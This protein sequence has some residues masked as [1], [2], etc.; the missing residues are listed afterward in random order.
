[1]IEQRAQP[2]SSDRELEPACQCLPYPGGAAAGQQCHILVN[3]AVCASSLIGRFP[4]LR[5]KRNR[6]IHCE[7]EVLG[8]LLAA[9][10]ILS[11]APLGACAV[12][13]KLEM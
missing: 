3:T 2:R 9:Q 10:P 8:L 1:M 13:G 11:H 6:S 4:I 7:R 12:A 5:E